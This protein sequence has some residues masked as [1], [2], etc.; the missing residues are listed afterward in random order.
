MLHLLDAAGGKTASTISSA[1][2]YR[3]ER[4]MGD[5]A[6]ATRYAGQLASYQAAPELFRA[7]AYFDTLRDALAN[8][9]LYIS[10]PSVDVRVELQDRES[11][12]DV[13]KPK[14]Q[15]EQ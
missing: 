7:A 4:H 15:D 9:R 12:M 8:A 10:N 13:F 5:R 3:W 11:G 1:K 2:A 6:R 14:T